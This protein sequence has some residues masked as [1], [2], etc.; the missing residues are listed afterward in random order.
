MKNNGLKIY[1]VSNY[2]NQKLVS[3]IVLHMSK[4]TKYDIKSFVFKY[5][6]YLEIINVYKEHIYRKDNAKLIVIDDYGILPFMI[7]GKMKG[8]VVA[9]LEDEYS[10]K[11]TKQHNNSNIIIL[12]SMALGIG[13]MLSI[14]DAFLLS[15]FEKGRHLERIEMLDILLDKEK[16]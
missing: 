16:I 5:N 11:L 3:D 14:I 4:H 1:I 6:I 7:L 9:V 8:S 13:L 10:A 12:P 15:D 2:E